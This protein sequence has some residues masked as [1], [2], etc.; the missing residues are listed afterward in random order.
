MQQLERFQFRQLFAMITKL[1]RDAHGVDPTRSEK[2]DIVPQDA[3]RI[4]QDQA[5]R[6]S[7]GF[8]ALGD[9]ERDYTGSTPSR[10][11]VRTLWAKSLQTPETFL[12][13]MV[14][15]LARILIRRTR[16]R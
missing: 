8:K 10:Q 2:V 3:A 4:K 9:L 13:I 16:R 15:E 6:F 11:Q 5:H 1:L 7:L 14:D 12:D